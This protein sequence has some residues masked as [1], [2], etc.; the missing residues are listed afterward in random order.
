MTQI[1]RKSRRTVLALVAGLVWLAV[2][3]TFF[4][5]VQLAARAPMAVLL[6]ATPKAV[7][8]KVG[9]RYLFEGDYRQT[10]VEISLPPGPHKLRIIRDGFITHEITVHGSA[11]EKLPIDTVLERRPDKA[12]GP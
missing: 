1:T 4:Q 5:T 8:V 3:A 7:K 9:S 2:G 12:I 11:G 6:N 10:P